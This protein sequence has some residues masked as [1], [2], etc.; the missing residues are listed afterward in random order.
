MEARIISLQDLYVQWVEE[1]GKTIV[2]CAAARPA[3]FTVDPVVLKQLTTDIFRY[4]KING[5][6]NRRLFGQKLVGSFLNVV[7]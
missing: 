4:Q 7:N 2:I 6:P 1:N 3:I 5:L